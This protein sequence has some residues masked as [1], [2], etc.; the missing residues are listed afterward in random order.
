MTDG[1]A[2]MLQKRHWAISSDG[3]VNQ[4]PSPPQIMDL[5]ATL[6]I[7]VFGVDGPY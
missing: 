3:A 4:D 7:S 2:E 6:P 5:A 1:A